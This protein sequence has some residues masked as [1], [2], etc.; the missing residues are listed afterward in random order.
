MEFTIK[1]YKMFS[2][3]S[4]RFSPRLWSNECE[5]WRLVLNLHCFVILNTIKVCN[6]SFCVIQDQNHVQKPL[7]KS[8][9]KFA[10]LII[11]YDYKLGR[12]KKT[13]ETS[14]IRYKVSGQCTKNYAYIFGRLKLYKFTYLTEIGRSSSWN[15]LKV[16]S[17]L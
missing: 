14:R 8:S 4:L 16:H 1:L 15:H 12:E 17:T 7:L 9:K 13:V 10:V 5:I 3:H 2:I 11:W 6:I